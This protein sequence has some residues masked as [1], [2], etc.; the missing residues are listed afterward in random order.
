M[1]RPDL[2]NSFLDQ[3]ADAF[4]KRVMERMN[5]NGVTSAKGTRGHRGPSKMKGR[6]LDM[7]CRYPGSRTGRRDPGSGSSVRST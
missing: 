7:R 3:L 2:R 5:A 4:V 1:A 6:K